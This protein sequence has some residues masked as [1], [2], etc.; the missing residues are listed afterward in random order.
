[1]NGR[2]RMNVVIVRKIDVMRAQWMQISSP[3]GITTY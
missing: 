3:D 1:M 2:G